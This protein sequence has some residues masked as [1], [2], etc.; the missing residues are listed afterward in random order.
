MRAS[1]VVAVVALAT[2]VAVA[3]EPPT[4]TEPAAPTAAEPEPPPAAVL[5][6]PEP[7]IHNEDED[8]GP[9]IQVEQI[10]ITGNTATQS[11][12]IRRALPI[13][14]G[15]LIRAGDPRLRDARFKVL[16]LGYFL[17][18]QL[19]M[20]KGTARG[21]V[22]IEVK[23]VERG[24]FTL[25]RLWFGTNVLTPAWFGADVGDRNLFGLGISIGGGFIYAGHGDIDGSRNQLATELR[26]SDGS[27]F[28][29]PFGAFGS[30]TFLQGSDPYRVSGTSADDAADFKAF[31]YR[32]FGGR[33]GGTYDLT[34]LTRISAGLRLEQITA[35]LPVAPT[36]VL[37]DGR[38]ATV[39]LH[40]RPGESYVSSVGASIDRDTRPDPI[41]PHSGGRITVAAEI[42][43][44]QYTFATL[45]GGYEH[46]WPLRNERHTIGLR[47]AG[48]VVI[49]DAPRFDRIYI[50][51]VDHMLTPRALGLVLSTAAPLGILGTRG[52]KPSYG[53][54][55]G[56]VSLEY[57]ARLFRGTG[58][59]RVYGGD[60]FVGAGLW[61]LAETADLQA[62]DTGVWK[63][64]PIDVYLDA[65]VRIDTE[66]GVF[67][68]TVSNA[69]GRLR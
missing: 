63:A 60:L 30:V 66:V 6:D 52:D 69:L 17:D 32:R 29:T 49:G 3:D 21:Q 50:S 40:L 47:L 53:D 58:K 16:A 34:T 37:P 28:G 39:D 51:D 33:I 19:A 9:L 42:G 64:L 48:G 4:T 54:L 13:E 24:T 65:G 26:V 59:D 15:D 56:A 11:E 14:P 20:H 46:W 22:V 1:L 2:R 57:A 45:F 44:G 5:E 55:G 41:L 12:L 23:V 8:A 35:T 36:Q 18:V 62:R 67:E 7:A 61:G 31:P 25:N 38:T 27:L 68:L 10:D 43:G